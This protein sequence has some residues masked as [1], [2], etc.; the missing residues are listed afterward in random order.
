M[1]FMKKILCLIV[2]IMIPIT[3]LADQFLDDF[4]SYA[5]SMYGISEIKPVFNGFPKTYASD[6]IEIMDDGNT[7]TLYAENKDVIDLIAAGCCAMRAIDNQ[8]NMLDQYGRILHAYFMARSGTGEKRATTDS[9]MLI[10][11]SI[12]SGLTIIKLVR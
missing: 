3:A 9:G 7:V 10:F 6:F 4:N 1:V 8:G 2:C 5:V 12:D 11:C